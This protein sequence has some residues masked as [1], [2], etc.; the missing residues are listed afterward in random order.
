MYIAEENLERFMQFVAKNIYPF[1]V[2]SKSYQGFRKFELPIRTNLEMVKMIKAEW[3]DYLAQSPPPHENR[4]VLEMA[5]EY[6]ARE[7]LKNAVLVENAEET[8]QII[9]KSKI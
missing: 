2:E 8:T 9:Y 3:L 5:K 6:S 7:T 1:K 4:F